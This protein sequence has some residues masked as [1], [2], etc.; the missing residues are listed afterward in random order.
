[1]GYAWT[2]VT[3]RNLEASLAFYTE[4][5]G[6]KVARRFS[7]MAGVELAFLTDG[8][9]KT[10]LELMCHAREEAIEHK[11]FIS[12][13]FTCKSLEDTMALLHAKGYA[14]DET[15]YSPVPSMRFIYASDPDGLKVQLIE[16]P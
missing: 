10:E 7:P 4:I 12:V 3:V 6:L 16:Q 9:S 8:E 1:M 15:V 5:A 11:P 13:G 14:F 2:T